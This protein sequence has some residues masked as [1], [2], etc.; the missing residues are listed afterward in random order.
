VK[1]IIVIVIV[2]IFKVLEKFFSKKKS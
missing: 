2:A 1:T